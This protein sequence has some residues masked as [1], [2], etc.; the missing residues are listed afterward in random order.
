MPFYKLLK[1]Q[2]PNPIQLHFKL[3]QFLPC[4]KKIIIQYPLVGKGSLLILG[5]LIPAKT[6]NLLLSLSHKSRETH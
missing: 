2:F 1:K 6:M 4:A 3:I 5:A